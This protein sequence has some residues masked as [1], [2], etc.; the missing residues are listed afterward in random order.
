MIRSTCVAV[1]SCVL[2]VSAVSA[3][4]SRAER[5]L[6]VFT[7]AGSGGRIAKF[8]SDGTTVVD[9]AI[10]EVSGLIGI[11]TAAPW[12]QLTIDSGGGMVPGMRLTRA[13][14][15]LHPYV[16]FLLVTGGAYPYA[17]VQVGD[18]ITWRP[19]VLQPNG[20]HVGIRTTNPSA[21]L[22]IFGTATQDTLV[23]IGVDSSTG[24]VLNIGHGGGTFGRG[25]AFFNARDAEPSGL[26][27][28]LRFLTADVERMIITKDGRVGIA[29]GNPTHA[30]DVQ[31]E[32]WGNAIRAIDPAPLATG[33]GAGVAFAVK[34]T[35]NGDLN[36]V[37]GI[38]GTKLTPVSGDRAGMMLLQV[39]DA[40]GN[41]LNVAE[42]RP[43][44]LTVNGNA[45]FNGVVTGTSITATYQD[46][47][48]WVPSSS[49]LEAGTVVVL[50]PAIG[51]GVRASGSAYDTSVAGV[52]SAQP[53][54]VLG[55]AGEE[56]EQIATT[57]RV[58]VKVDASV[59]PIAVGDL[60]VTSDRPGH[61]MRSTPVDVAGTR[62]HRPGTI[63]GKALQPLAGGQGEIL[64]LLSLQ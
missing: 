55:I 2:I 49:D 62:M 20:G 56:K 4:E 43:G 22:H 21:P 25:A 33:F 24:P 60:L 58:V 37:A 34:Y 23:S 11:N 5:Q 50:D 17:F 10:H 63:I 36:D 48:E 42:L 40:A 35:S 41:P 51:N 7:N 18:N 57:G 1:L 44:A 15:S 30:L 39:T 28:S 54:I 14:D 53:G 45:H 26:N 13:S 3:Q 38:R 27:P 6:K 8:A 29:M 31:A 46:L 47:A 64:V 32:R 19:L 59:A 52:V 16:D 61:A 12:R 9:S